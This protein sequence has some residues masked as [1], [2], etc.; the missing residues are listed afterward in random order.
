ME[1]DIWEADENFGML[2]KE[3]Y[4]HVRSVQHVFAISPSTRY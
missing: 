3:H 2:I 1:R 4:P